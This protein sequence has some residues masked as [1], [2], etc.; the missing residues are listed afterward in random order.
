MKWILMIF[1]AMISMLSSSQISTGVASYYANKFDGRKT[2]SGEVFRQDSL[3]AAHKNLPFGT[4]LKVTNLNND[5]V[6]YVKVNDRLPQ[7]SKRSIDLS[8]AAAKQ[9]NFIKAGLTKVSIQEVR[10]N[11]NEWVDESDY[12]FYKDRLATLSCGIVDTATVLSEREKLM[13]FDTTI[14]KT[15]IAQYYRDLS[16][17]YYTHYTHVQRKEGNYP[18]IILNQ[19][20]YYGYKCTALRVRE[21]DMHDLV[22]MLF[23]AK[24]CEKGRI[25][26]EKFKRAFPTSDSLSGLESWA[27]EC[28]PQN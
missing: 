13:N 24:E 19:A 5:S 27:A 8:L 9:L 12:F 20:I 16:W 23:F 10:R 18:S 1:G 4:M 3:T 22:H 26:L 7:S 15:N 28:T 17:N 6:V 21:N 14:V 11:R 2:S 25:E